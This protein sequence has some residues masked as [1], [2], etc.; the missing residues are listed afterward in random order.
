MHTTI[1][2]FAEAVETPWET[3]SFEAAVFLAIF[4]MLAGISAG[5]W[6]VWQWRT[7]HRW[8]QAE[9][10]RTLL[11][12]FFKAKPTHD[13]WRMVDNE[14]HYIDREGNKLN[15][16]M[17]DVRRALRLERDQNDEE[18][19]LED[20]DE[21]IWRKDAYIRWC[22]DSLFYYLERLEQS[23]N[24]KVVQFDDLLTPTTYYISLMAKDKKLFK[25]YAEF[26]GFDRAVKFMEQ[27]IER[28]KLS[29]RKIH[30]KK[31]N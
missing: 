30:T 6:A 26:V 12:E 25:M 9:L 11:D 2:F 14:R 13:A 23:H 21:N 29:P 31:I 4:T 17:D 16:T 10:A 1:M 28:Q 20:A 24:I 19:L 18:K 7:E 15:I 27:I 8:K 3:R 22:F 5:F